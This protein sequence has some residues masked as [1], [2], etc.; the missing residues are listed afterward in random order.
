MIIKQSTDIHR[1]EKNNFLV[2]VLVYFDELFDNARRG[3]IGD[4]CS[5]RCFD[6][7]IHG[8]GDL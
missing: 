1:Y 3:S 6:R 4:F 7:G 5:F 2:F 8:E